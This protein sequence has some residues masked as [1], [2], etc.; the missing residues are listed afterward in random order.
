MVAAGKS[1]AMAGPFTKEDFQHVVPAD[2]KLSKQ[3]IES[4]YARGEPLNATGDDLKFIGM[5]INGISTGQVYLG[6]DGRLWCWN[7]DGEPDA[8][9]KDIGGGPKYMNPVQPSSPM[10]QGFAVEVGP[11]DGKRVFTLD[12]GGFGDIKFTNRYPMGR[13]NFSDA[14]CPVDVQLDAYTPFVPLNRDDSSYPVIVMRYTIKNTSTQPQEVAIGGWIENFSNHRTAAVNANGVRL[15]QYRELEGLSIVECWARPLDEAL[16]RQKKAEAEATLQQKAEQNAQSKKPPKDTSPDPNTIAFDWANDFG[17]VALGLLGDKEPDFV[18][19][20]RSDAGPENLFQSGPA[21]ESSKSLQEGSFDDKAYASLGRRFTLQPGSEETV[22]FTLSWRFPNARFVTGFGRTVWSRDVNF[23][24]TQWPDASAAAHAV[25]TRE[26]ELRNATQ[27]WTDT[28]YDS[29]LPHWFLERTLI[30][31]DCM[32]TQLTARLAMQDGMYGLDEGVNCCQGNCTHVWHYAQG[33]A[34]LFP[35]IERECRDKVD[36]GR[37]FKFD[38]GAMNFRC[39]TKT[40]RE[41]TDGQCGTILRVFRESQMTTDLSFLQSI[42]DRTK[43][44]MDYV[45]KTWDTN[46][47]G[48]LSGAQHN[49]LDKAWYGQIHWLINLYHAAL[50]AAAKMAVQMNQPA[51]AARYEQLVAKGSA[52]MVEML[53]NEDFGYFV[54]IPELPP[55]KTI[56][57]TTGCHIDQVLGEFWLR[58]LG[59][60]PILPRDKVRKA[61]SALWTYNFSP[62]I[63]DFRKLEK[64]GRWFAAE[65]E[66]GLIMCTFPHGKEN[67][68]KKNFHRYFNECMSGF[69]WQV[70][71]TM[72][73]EGMLEEGLAIGKAIYDRYRPELRNP[74]NEVECGDHY[75][76]AL[77]SYSAFMAICGYRYDGPAGKLGFGPKMQQENFRAAFTTAEGW[78]SFSQ[79]VADGVQ[80][81]SV[82]IVYGRLTLNECALDN[83]AGVDVNV[84]EVKLDGQ[85]IESTLEKTTKSSTVKFTKPITITSGGELQVRLR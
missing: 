21:D 52:S 19:T 15:S 37:S 46:E 53:W 34:R 56:G 1:P 16:N 33:L 50:R 20:A 47:D 60:D 72:I 10:D 30:P 35:V 11:A 73:W 31:I 39:S 38:T 49:T 36:F 45:I 17:A 7:L 51:V 54:H 48:L 61:L 5:P 41:A 77:S 58:N 26:K 8:A 63:G 18:S 80:A 40:F 71:A 12:S 43:L 62:N 84:A 42:W 59:L 13:V 23:Y 64:K 3:W 28:W 67:A 76:R 68:Q 2:K 44:T 25:T 14:D 82:E 74:Y 6:G 4:L 22:A 57:S 81:A 32:Q 24:S 79:T 29:T 55:E 9:W 85:L 75:S 69:E 70:A 78:G 65:G 27:S 83:V 66:A